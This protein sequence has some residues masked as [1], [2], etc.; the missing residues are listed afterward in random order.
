MGQKRLIR[1]ICV[2]TVLVAV[3]V[4]AHTGLSQVKHQRIRSS[5][6]NRFGGYTFYS[7]TGKKTG[8]SK[9]N[10]KGGYDYYDGQG[11]KV[12]SLKARDKRGRF[13]NY[14]DANGIKTGTLRKRASGIYYYQDINSGSIVDSIPEKRG[15]LGSLSP[16]TFQGEE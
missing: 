10:R 14:Y 6:K 1:I 7:P 11:N 13:Y 2:V 9:P 16:Q 8:L 4:I 5:V 15:E 3:F 12:G